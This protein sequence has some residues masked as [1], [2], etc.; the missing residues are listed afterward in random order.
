MTSFEALAVETHLNNRLINIDTQQL[1]AQCQA[2]DTRAI[3]MLIRAHHPT[4]Y[5]LALSVL[6]DPAD[7]DEAAQEALLAALAA[8]DSY[9]GKAAFSTWLYTITLNACRQHLRRQ[10]FQERLKNLVSRV[11]QTESADLEAPEQQVIRRDRHAALRQAV[12]RLG[13]KHRLPVIL[14]YYHNLPIAEIAQ[15]LAV[16]EGT[17]HSRLNTARAQ[18]RLSL[19]KEGVAWPPSH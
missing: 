14:R 4:V 3:E 16:N 17:I 6:N 8:L 5:R 10:R 18:L 7:A 19:D 11:W 2:G 9:Q 15:M 13:E 12:N 1:V